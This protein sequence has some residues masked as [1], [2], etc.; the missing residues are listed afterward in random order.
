MNTIYKKYNV[1]HMIRIVTL[2][3]SSISMMLVS[4]V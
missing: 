2:L 4:V 3:T 1:C